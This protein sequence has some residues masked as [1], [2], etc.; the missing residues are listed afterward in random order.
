[1][2]RVRP[3]LIASVMIWGTSAIA[4]QPTGD[5]CN[6]LASIIAVGETVAFSSTDAEALKYYAFCEASSHANK[7][8]L[9][10]TYGGFGLGGSFEDQKNK[11][12]CSQQKEHYRIEAVNYTRAKV[13]F[14]K[15]LDVVAAC[16]NATKR[17]W[18]IKYAQV[19]KNSV[20]LN[21]SNTN[22]TGGNLLGIDLLPPAVMSCTG[23]P[24]AFPQN[25]TTTKP[26]S[27][28]CT[29]P[30]TSQTINGVVVS[31]AP[32][33]T[34]NL[35]LDDNQIPIKMPGSSGSIL[36]TVLADIAR[37]DRTS[38]GLTGSL[39]MLRSN[40]LQW[41]GGPAYGPLVSAPGGDQNNLVLTECPAGHYM[42]GVQVTGNTG[43]QC[44]GCLNR[45][46]PV[47]R[48]LNS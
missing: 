31:T 16:L 1:M 32:E 48:P 2:S 14:D 17:G 20:S 15:A 30:E 33:V 29:R 13:V 18:Q 3:F 7:T 27:M 28:L 9:N 35:R 5:D 8:G 37:L 24:S 40:L 42:V 4:Q 26:L 39:T 6:K 21:L 19:H 41:K 11:E 43:G 44:T 46:M 25:I 23:M 22:G 12:Y 47:C 36:D 34:I 45:I 10:I 38:I